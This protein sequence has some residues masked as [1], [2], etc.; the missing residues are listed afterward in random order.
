MQ[1]P[2]LVGIFLLFPCFCFWLV[3]FHFCFV[4]LF[5]TWARSGI[6]HPSIQNPLSPRVRPGDQRGTALLPG[7]RAR[8]GC[9][10]G[11]RL[12]PR[13][14]PRARVVRSWDGEPQGSGSSPAAQFLL[15]QNQR[16]S[17]C[18]ELL[19]AQKGT[20]GG[21]DELQSARV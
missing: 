11:G 16:R 18:A 5:Y 20:G 1:N 17:P 9:R 10:P 3:F 19:L 13:T 12:S 15:R 14:S 6:W 8:W 21:K 2:C 7:A 4:S